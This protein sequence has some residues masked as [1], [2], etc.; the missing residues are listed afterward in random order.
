M[1][2]A[3]RLA[4]AYSRESRRGGDTIH[5]CAE[6]I[7][8]SGKA[9]G[10][11][12]E[13][14]QIVGIGNLCEFV[15]VLCA[16]VP[17]RW[18]TWAEGCGHGGHGSSLNFTDAF[19]IY[20]RVMPTRSSRELPPPHFKIPSVGATDRIAATATVEVF[21]IPCRRHDTQPTNTL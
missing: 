5:H 12:S 9:H 10:C 20:A 17:P 1:V 3:A 4:T 14:S 2:L 6:P 19:H 18:R 11:D 15:V 16:E 7:H 21:V 13:Y 8:Q